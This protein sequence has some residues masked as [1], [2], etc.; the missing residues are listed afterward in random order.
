LKVIHL[1][2]VEGTLAELRELFVEGAKKEARKQAMKAGEKVVRA[3][4]RKGTRKLSDWQKY[5][6]NKKNHIKFKSGPKKGR[7]D[8]SKMSKAFKRSRRKK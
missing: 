8:L 4:V 1:V 7:L 2:K 6:K 5:L 3:G